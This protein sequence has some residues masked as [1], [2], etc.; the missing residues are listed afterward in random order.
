MSE[1]LLRIDDRLLHGQVLLGWASSWRPERVVLASDE[2]AQDAERSAFYTSLAEGDYDIEVVPVTTA[3]AA[4]SEP[5]PPTRA[6]YVVGRA[7]DARRLVELGARIDQINVGGMHHAP[8]RKRLLD[9]VHLSE[10]DARDLRALLERGVRLEARDLPGARGVPID[11]RM[12]A[13]VW[14]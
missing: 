1:T 5:R 9:Y 3:A 4:L 2:V 14:P 12:L 11:R 7:A 10:Q 8:G 13:R 6:L